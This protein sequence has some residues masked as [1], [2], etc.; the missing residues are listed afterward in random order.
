MVSGVRNMSV[1]VKT[2]AIVVKMR[3][4]RCRRVLSPS[5]HPCVRHVGCSCQGGGHDVGVGGWDDNG[6]CCCCDGD[7]GDGGGH[8]A[9]IHAS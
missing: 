8:D 9:I 5:H 4:S 7:G 1:V 3:G 6:H 2:K